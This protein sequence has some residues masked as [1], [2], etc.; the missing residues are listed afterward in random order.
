M[1]ANANWA[2]WIFASVAHYLKTV[3]VT[4]SLSVMVEGLDDRDKAFMQAS[5]RVEIRINGP[6]IRE[7][8]DEYYEV[9]VV[10][11]VLLTSRYDG[12][13]NGYIFLDY[14][15]LYLSAMD[16]AIP[17]YTFGSQSD[18]LIGCLR[19]RSGRNNPIRVLHFGQIE[20][21]DHVKQA[22]VDAS[23]IM[24]LRGN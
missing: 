3:A 7:L 21:T 17:V 20:K 18:D 15:G 5:D 19:P 14:L 22:M 16:K 11:N 13:K 12:H 24:H 4:S 2:R 8:S 1:P 10:A 23:Y 9:Q 6:F